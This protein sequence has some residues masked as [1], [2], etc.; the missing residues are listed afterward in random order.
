MRD[1]RDYKMVDDV[2][3]MMAVSVCFAG[4]VRRPPTRC[5][6][7]DPTRQAKLEGIHRPGEIWVNPLTPTRREEGDE[8][9][10]R[11]KN[12]TCK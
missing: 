8:L 7:D 1:Q 2:N 5:K 12:K 3:H 10:V 4:F 11:W 6:S 9:Q